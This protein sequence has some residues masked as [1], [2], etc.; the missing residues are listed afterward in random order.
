[1][2]VPL[3]VLVAVVLLGAVPNA[4]AVI[5][6]LFAALHGSR[7]HLG[8]GEV[9]VQELPRVAV[10]VPAWNEAAVLRFSVDRMMALDYPSDRLRVVVV[11]DAS[12]DET[13]EVMADKIAHWGSRVVHLR[14]EN[15]GQGKAHTLN[16]GL[17][18]ILA[19]DWAQAVLITDA[20]VVFEAT[21]V[22]RM[23]RHL[24]DDRVGA[25][26]AFITEASPDPN[27]LNRYI[28]YEY[29]AAQAVARRAQ[30]VVGAQAC[31]AGGAQLH[32][33]ANLER[34][35]GAIDTTTLAEDTVTTFLTQLSGHRVVFEGNARCLAEEPA[36][37]VG[38]WKQRLRWARGNV[39]VAKRFRSVFFR[40]STVHRLGRPWFGLMWWA[41]L[42]LPVLMI[43]SSA[44]LVTLWFTDPDVGRDA[45]RALWIVNALGF[46]FTTAFTLLTDPPTARRAWRQ[47]ITFPGLVNLLIVLSVI[48]PRPMGALGERVFTAV[49]IGWTDH[50]RSVL[51]LIVYVW[52]AACMLAA[53]AV[54]R[55]AKAGVSI[56]VLDVAV[57]VVGYG[58]LLCAVTFAAYVAEARG[59]ASTWDKTVKT[60]K[61][62]AAV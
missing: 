40:P 38:L 42:L 19:D 55:L 14:R 23:T 29:V 50:V 37:V 49:G 41:T 54:Y 51:Q 60:G 16:H 22:R 56:R 24:G 25:V 59:A 1:M 2:S 45:F 5:Q 7:S 35:G 4:L 62:G 31:L 15:G 21:A 28:G 36:D 18:E 48:A 9:D 33:R 26:T 20:D 27:G 53:Y 46:V 43:V 12:T 13:V 32:T 58:P 17:R 11:D 52:C 10:L 30:N 8:D 44:A 39:Q 61:V 6:V 47:A 34:L 3:I 57:L